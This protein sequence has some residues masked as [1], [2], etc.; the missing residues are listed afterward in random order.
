MN[1]I[2]RERANISVAFSSGLNRL[3]SKEM[4]DDSDSAQYSTSSSFIKKFLRSIVRKGYHLV[5]PV[6]NPIALRARHYLL[7]ELNEEIVQLQKEQQASLDKL[8]L[9]QSQ[10][11]ASSTPIII[12]CGQDEVLIETESGF[13]LCST[14]DKAKLGS[15][16]SRN[17]N[18]TRHFIQ[19]F[20][21]PHNIFIDVGANL[22][23]YTLAAAKALEGKGKIFAFETLLTTKEMLDKSVQVNG[24]TNIIQ[25]HQAA[26]YR[27][28]EV[29]PTKQRVDLIKIN[30]Q[31]GELE[32]LESAK[33]IIRE[34]PSIG[35]IVKFKPHHLKY[36]NQTIEKWFK[37]FSDLE[38]S[39]KVINNS[40]GK[41]EER[42]LKQL[43]AIC[44]IDIFFAHQNSSAWKKAAL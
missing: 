18:G 44:S 21:N 15:L 26:D 13:I 11:K 37:A 22:G 40:T 32:V 33:S 30:A 9:I 7:A 6:L 42:S 23:V 4:I 3:Q 1:K 43:E 10:I 34:N 20:L 28:A 38:L 39:F 31:G 5:K 14:S 35:L 19:H 36:A 25:I 24:Y 12:P 16:I 17:K 41:L 2:Q 8:A 29:I 27:L